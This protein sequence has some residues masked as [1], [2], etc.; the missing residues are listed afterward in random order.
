MYFQVT[1]HTMYLIPVFQRA[2]KLVESDWYPDI[3]GLY[4]EDAEHHIAEGNI[5]NN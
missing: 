3:E 1:F 2:Q 5:S 4:S